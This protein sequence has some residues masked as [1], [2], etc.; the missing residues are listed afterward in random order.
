VNRRRAAFTLVEVLSGILLFAMGVM[1]V[2]AVITHG[3][4]IANRAQ[5]DASAW[6]TAESVLR[7]PLPMGGSV[8]PSTGLLQPWSWARSGQTWVATEVDASDSTWRYTT[9]ATDQPSDVLVAD[10]ADPQANNPALFPP[11]GSPQAGCASGW[12][13]GYYVERREQ[14]R[15]SDRISREARLVEVR[16]DVY[17]AGYVGGDGRPLATLVD[18]YVR[19]DAP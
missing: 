4:G 16:V 5:G 14:S 8:D 9:W 2:I 11:G 19:Q 6:M 7:D 17:W 15:A 3:L 10:M 1:A 12:L 18:R 13:N